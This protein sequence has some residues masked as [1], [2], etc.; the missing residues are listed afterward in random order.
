VLGWATR[1]RLHVAV[2][3]LVLAAAT[4]GLSMLVVAGGGRLTT[5]D[6]RADVLPEL[7]ELDDVLRRDAFLDGR[8]SPGDTI[9][10]GD[11]DTATAQAAAVPQY[12]GSADG[13]WSF[14]GP[15]NI[16]GRVPDIAPDPTQQGRVF[17]ATATGGSGRARTAE[18]R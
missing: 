16:G 15:T 11:L 3:L 8:Q 2:R 1:C 9:T 13:H 6:A 10:A 18:R 7:L 17:L 14:V 5:N 12:S 4:A